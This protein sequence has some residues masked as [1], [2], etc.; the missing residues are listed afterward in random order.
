MDK[1]I[2]GLKGGLA[3][4]SVSMHIACPRSGGRPKGREEEKTS[5]EYVVDNGMNVGGKRGGR[6]WCNG[7]DEGLLI[8]RDGLVIVIVL[9]VAVVVVFIVGVNEGKVYF[10]ARGCCLC[11]KVNVRSTDG[12]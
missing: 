9:I 1:R 5:G 11:V 8:I 12:G 7:S 10:T 2:T 4:G 6:S 3:L